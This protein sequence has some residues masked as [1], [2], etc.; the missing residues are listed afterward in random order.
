MERLRKTLFQS[1]PERGLHQV[2]GSGTLS[3]VLATCRDIGHLAMTRPP[4]FRV[5][6]S[7][8]SDELGSYRTEVAR[9]LRRKEL[10]VREQKHFRQGGSLLLH[11]LREYVQYCEVR[12][13]AALAEGE[14]WLIL[15]RGQRRYRSG[16]YARGRVAGQAAGEHV[17]VTCWLSRAGAVAS[18]RWNWTCSSLRTPRSSYWSVA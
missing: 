7:A 5:F 17:L 12:V 16:G 10:V 14:P 11:T 18:S 4:S 9:V 2:T 1:L 15:D 8:V 6:V 13:A 3:V